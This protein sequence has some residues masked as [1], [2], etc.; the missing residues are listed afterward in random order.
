MYCPSMDTP[1][2]CAL[3]PNKE[4]VPSLSL[5]YRLSGS[6]SSAWE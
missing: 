2:V 1:V 5:S 4:L 3:W 6:G